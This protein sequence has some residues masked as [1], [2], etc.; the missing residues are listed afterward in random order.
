MKRLR[1]VHSIGRCGGTVICKCLGAMKDLLLLSE[2]HPRRSDFDPLLQAKNW[3]GFPPEE[4]YDELA[5][6]L[7]FYG[8]VAYVL[9]EAEKRDLRLVVRD[10][11]YQDFYELPRYRLTTA[12]ALAPLDPTPL[13]VSIVRHPLQQWL[14]LLESGFL[15]GHVDEENYYLGARLF[16]EVASR[17]RWTL[18]YEDFAADPHGNLA[19]VCDR[20]ELPY[21]KNWIYDWGKNSRVT[22]ARVSTPEITTPKIREPPPGTLERALRCPDYLDACRVLGYDPEGESA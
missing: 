6:R 15:S 11:A 7:S 10:W 3:H 12:D 16:A 8:K 4:E 22:G 5:R 17:T 19:L 2:I 9:E 13:A 21:D 14:S 20:L 1:Y 18:K